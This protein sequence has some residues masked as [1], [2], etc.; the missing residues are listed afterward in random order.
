M[1]QNEQYADPLDRA[2]VEQ[3]RLLE[4]QLRVARAWITPQKKYRGTCYNCDEIL[5]PP[6]RYCDKDCR[7]D[8]EARTSRAKVNGIR[9]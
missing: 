5:V 6:H 7:D 9:L 1:S 8:H 2:V 4:E 3:E